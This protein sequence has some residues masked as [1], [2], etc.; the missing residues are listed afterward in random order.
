MRQPLKKVCSC[1]TVVWDG[2]VPL[3]TAWIECW[4]CGLD[5]SV[6]VTW[7]YRLRYVRSRIAYKVR[8]IRGAYGGVVVFWLKEFY[9]L[10]REWET[11]HGR[12]YWDGR[13][14]PLPV[15]AGTTVTGGLSE[16]EAGIKE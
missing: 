8:R 12:H 3:P 1:G 4:N 13:T 5:H 2:S 14:K 11:R 10:P 15:P 7:R 9:W 16:A 6:K